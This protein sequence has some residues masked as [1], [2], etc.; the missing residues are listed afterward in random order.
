L[1][2]ESSN[3]TQNI[4][5]MAS[6]PDWPAFHHTQPRLA[7]SKLGPVSLLGAVI[8]PVVAIGIL[9][10]SVLWYEG[11]FEGPYLVLALLIFPMTY[12]TSLARDASDSGTLLRDIITG[13]LTMAV[14][15]IL[16]GWASGTLGAFNQHAMLAWFVMTPPALFAVHRLI[17]VLVLRLSA[18]EGL[19]RTAVIAGANETGCKLAERI[20]ANPFLGTRV[21]GYFDDRG[22]ERTDQNGDSPSLGTLDQL[23][24]Y[25]KT[26]HVDL[27]YIAL[28][29][30]SQPRIL[31]LLDDLHD[32]TAS[33]YF[34]PDVYLF[35]LVQARVDTIGGLPVVAVRES[36]F[37]GADGMIK[38]ASDIV[39]ATAILVMIA[40]LMLAIAAGV[41]LSSPGPAL[42]RQRRYGLDGR[43]IVVYKFRSMT[44]LEDGNVIR[45]ATRGDNRVTRFGSFLRSTSLDELPQFINVLQGRMSVVGPRPHAVAHNEMYRKVIRGYMIRHKVKPG[46]TGLAQVNGMRGETDSI[47]KMEMRI[48]YDLAYLRSWSLWLDLKIVLKTIVVVLKRQNAH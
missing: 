27:I 15:L 32:T 36:P 1:R 31:R 45:Q 48:E 5:T 26:H 35:D 42:F 41:K 46:I 37:Y 2:I 39:L 9:V 10:M 19:H 33:V 23:A 21:T 20:R 3:T 38:R 47:D 44:V 13:W 8:D 11:R 16:V 34:A 29:M 43:E 30:A 24:D 4:A 7:L 12:P 28:P 18:A 22:A 14:V 40:P 25:V 6:I 17:P